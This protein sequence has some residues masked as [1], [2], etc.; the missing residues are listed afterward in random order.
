[1][2]NFTENSRFRRSTNVVSR[3]IG[4]ET[5]VVPIKGGVGDLDAIFSFNAVGSEVWGLMESDRSFDELAVWVV[6]H[7]EASRGQVETDLSDFIGELV[8]AGL[9]TIEPEQF[10]GTKAGQPTHASR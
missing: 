3:E 10:L 8:E 6:D 9:V 7:Y 1:M 4:S 2:R 5:L